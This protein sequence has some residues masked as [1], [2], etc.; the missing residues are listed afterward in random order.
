MKEEMMAA[1]QRSTTE[2]VPPRAPVAFYWTFTHAWALAKRR[3][4]QIRRRP[5]EL[6]IATVQPTILVLL[7]RY[8]F[9][10]AIRVPGTSYTNY[11]MAG[12]FV[13]ASL[14]GS[15]STGI[16]VATDLQQG[17][18]DRFRSLPMA[19]SAVLTG[20]TLADLVRNGFVVLVIGGVGL[21]VGFRPAG[22]PLAWVAATGLLLLTTLTFSWLAVLLGLLVS[23]PE[24]VQGASLLIFYPLLFGSNAFVP[25]S[26]MPDWLQTFADHQPISAVIGAVRGLLLNQPDA[27]AI[28]QALAWCGGLLL[29]F[30]ALSTLVYEH[31]TAR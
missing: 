14:I 12:V 27:G 20:R 7:F 10:G 31:R 26:T 16:G 13:L 22:S 15:L 3:L 23:S 25:T 4:L 21:L 29:V 19:H 2:A 17:L 6:L 1:P 8:V 30:I 18:I 5:D 28:E 9:G 11:L 24:A